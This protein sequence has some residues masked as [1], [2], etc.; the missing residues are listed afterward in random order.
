MN[1]VNPLRF[2]S[3]QKKLS[4][5]ITFQACKLF[6]DKMTKTILP[7]CQIAFLGITVIYHS[8]IEA[9]E[10]KHSYNTLVSLR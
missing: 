5:L 3:Q 6:S 4:K 9:W 1:F 8:K 10:R 7:N 2:T